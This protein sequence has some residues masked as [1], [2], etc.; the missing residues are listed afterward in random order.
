MRKISIVK[1]K[2]F[3]KNILA[4]MIPVALQQAINMGVNMMDTVMLGQMGEVQLSASSLANAFYNIYQIFCMGIIGGCSVLVAHYWG[5]G[6][7][8]KVKEVFSLAMRV[9]AF[10]AMV[11]ASVTLLFP[12]QIMRMFTSE[13]DVIAAGT[14]YLRITAF[15]YLIHGVGFVMAQLMRAVGEAKIGLY[16]SIVSFGINIGANWIF[17]FGHLGAP[18]MEI[19]GAAVGTLIARVAELL[20]TFCFVLKADKKLCLKMI[21]L[22]RRPSAEVVRK[23]LKVGVAVLISDGLLGFGSM[24]LSMVIGRLGKAAVS[25]NS[26][27]Q[28]V[29][30]LFTV[31]IA[32]VANASSIMIGHT[33][34]AGKKEEAQR[35]G[36]TFY[37]LSVVFGVLSALVVFL[38]G[39]LTMKLYKLE[40]ETILVTRQMMYA[41]T[42]I[43]L[44]Q[45]MQTVM[46]KGV[47]RGGGDTKFLMVADI[48][49]LWVVSLPL[50]YIT[51]I[52]LHC[53]A[54]MVMICLRSDYLFKD[55]WC[56][57]RLFSKKWIHDV[58]RK[59][60]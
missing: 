50:G 33:I 31:V 4:I 27:C 51:G 7:R 43:V 19:Q 13:Q 28:V 17:I 37:L 5:A 15:V 20:L 59:K 35:Q 1:E 53:P 3:Y 22:L 9:T 55:I 23:Y 11:F 46:T 44:I 60:V 58:A 39:P 40:P 21:D 2:S 42:F 8:G 54:W 26:I 14:G 45:C 12:D 10:F 49:F 29:D 48:L 41:Y 6:D 47:L 52:I 36:E 34:G 24:A 18:R 38:V 57:V 25:A 16:V 32:G 30:R 56:L